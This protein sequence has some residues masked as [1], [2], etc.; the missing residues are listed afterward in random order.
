MVPKWYTEAE[1]FAKSRPWVLKSEKEVRTMLVNV[2]NFCEPRN[3]T[4]L[5][6]HQFIA[7][8]MGLSWPSDWSKEYTPPLSEEGPEYGPVDVSDEIATRLTDRLP[9]DPLHCG[10]LILCGSLANAAQFDR[11]KACRMCEALYYIATCTL[12]PASKAGSFEEIQF[13]KEIS[14]SGAEPYLLM[15]AVALLFQRWDVPH[16]A[17]NEYVLYSRRRRQ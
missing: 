11:D 13:L 2:W 3:W 14:E 15:D 1:D 4:N 12:L 6:V 16:T 5:E 17:S 8:Q 7:L 9:Q 10:L